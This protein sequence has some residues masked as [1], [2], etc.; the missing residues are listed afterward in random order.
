MRS[1]R[2]TKS[3]AVQAADGGKLYDMRL[4]GGLNGFGPFQSVD[5]FHLFLREGIG[6]LP[7]SPEQPPEANELFHMHAVSQYATCFTHGDLNSR[8]ILAMGDDI[9]G[10]VE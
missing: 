5:D 3:G 4:S 10:I 6:A 2:P 7:D 9:V 1:L 8:N